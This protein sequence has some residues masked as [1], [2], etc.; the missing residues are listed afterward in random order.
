MVITREVRVDME[1]VIEDLSKAESFSVIHD[2]VN[3]LQ[4]RH[5]LSQSEILIN[6]I[7]YLFEVW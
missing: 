7:N 6:I 5:G 1:N 4:R 2:L 3:H